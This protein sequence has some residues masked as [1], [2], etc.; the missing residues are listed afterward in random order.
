MSQVRADSVRCFVLTGITYG[1]RRGISSVNLTA[2]NQV[3]W[4]TIFSTSSK[5]IDAFWCPSR[6][7]SSRN[8]DRMTTFGCGSSEGICPSLLSQAQ[9]GDERYPITT[10]KLRTKGCCPGFF[11]EWSKS[12]PRPEQMEDSNSIPIPVTS[13]TNFICS[14]KRKKQTNKQTNPTVYFLKGFHVGTDMVPIESRTYI[15]AKST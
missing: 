7:R 3:F 5:K 15:T 13:L 9:I 2:N 8:T 6:V 4:I 10:S 11:G 1:E 14:K 12:Q